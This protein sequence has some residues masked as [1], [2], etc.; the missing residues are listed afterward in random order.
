MNAASRQA[1]KQPWIR[2]RLGVWLDSPATT[3][4]APFL[5][6]L[7]LMVLLDRLNLASE[8]WNYALRT[9]AVLLLLLL[10]RPWRW[11]AAPRCTDLLPGTLVGIVVFLVW[12]LPELRTADRMPWL[13]ELYLRFGVRPLGRLPLR[14]H[15]PPCDPG[16][17]G[18]PL[19]WVRAGGSAFVIAMAEE[20]FWRGFVYRR[21]LE[22]DFT[23]V[24]TARYDREAFLITCVLFGLE[25]HRYLAGMVAGAAYGYLLLRRHGIWS[26]ILAHVVTNLLLGVYVL[27][28]GFHE[29]W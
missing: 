24:P 23:A 12:V 21:L 13:Q 7:L 17:C 10:C 2:R 4:V 8:A 14:P 22:P 29:F 16:V 3:H 20:F 11:Y 19:A 9:G 5:A 1:R 15:L 26:A 6:W 27:Y 28:T 18:W 25:H